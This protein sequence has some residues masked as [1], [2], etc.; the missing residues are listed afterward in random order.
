[1][2]EHVLM[3]GSGPVI[4]YGTRLRAMDESVRTTLVCRL[5]ALPAVLEPTGHQRVLAVRTDAPIA[6]V[7]ATAGA[8]HAVDP[9]TRITAFWEY[10]QDRAAA[11]GA[12][13]G[14]P[15]HAVGTVSAVHDKDVMRARLRAAGVDDTPAALVTSAADAAAFGADHGYPFVVKPVAAAG[16]FGVRIVRAEAEIPAA[17]AAASGDFAGVTRAEVLVESYH[18]G[19]QYSV[20]AF[21]EAGEHVVVA[22]TRKYS[23]PVTLVEL[24]HVTPAP[25]DPLDHK[26]IEEY[27]VRVLDALGVGFGPTHTEVVLTAT[28]P[29][30]IETHLR[31]GG[32]D[33]YALVHD[34]LGVDFTDLQVRQ[35]LR[36]CVLPD[37]RATL[38]RA[39][40]PR[41]EAIWYAP[42]AAEGTFTG[43]VEVGA[44]P[45]D[46][47]VTALIKPGT[48][49]A[50]LTG[51]PARLAKARAH[52]PTAEAA[53]AT[54][55][56]AIAA[57]GFDIRLTPPPP[58][59]V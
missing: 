58:A 26:E 51:S 15:A 44:V 8:L 9:V 11:V 43:M 40:T 29:R 5:D 41:H 2:A 1:M 20:E 23:D 45:E 4:D 56:S 59:T 46:A 38:D 21:S 50:P 13:L 32:D 18:D 7:V 47:V 10:D 25:L 14:L 30:I 17:F 16:S 37:L 12:A 55:R 48:D 6:E 31:V 22:V 27:V 3:F 39:R 36:Q 49:L 34:A 19:P 35:T 42:G 57:L 53:L 33:I 52:G 24:G 28:G 54:A